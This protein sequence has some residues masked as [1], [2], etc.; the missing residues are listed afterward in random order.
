MKKQTIKTLGQVIIL[1]AILAVITFFGQISSQYKTLKNVQ[2]NNST[3]QKTT[4]PYEYFFETNNGEVGVIAYM[5]EDREHAVLLINEEMYDLYQ[6]VSGSGARYTNDD[7]S[8]VF[9]EHQGTVTITIGDK[10]YASNNLIAV[11]TLAIEIEAYK[12]DCGDAEP[13]MCL[14]ANGELLYDN[15][16]GFDFVEGNTYSM[17]V[18]QI[19]QEDTPEKA[20]QYQYRLVTIFSVNDKI[21]D[22]FF[23][24]AEQ[25]WKDKYGVCHTCTPENGFGSNGEIIEM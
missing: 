18:A 20:N 2:L 12:Q 14:V 22:I 1:L 15:I 21:N 7:E 3:D 11:R 24:Q 4:D 10:T 25:V 6:S 8:V 9:W 5:S 16:Q 19:D 13:A 23:D 17:I